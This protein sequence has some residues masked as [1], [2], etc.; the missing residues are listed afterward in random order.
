MVPKCRRV[1]LSK[2]LTSF[3]LRGDLRAPKKKDKCKRRVFCMSKQLCRGCYNECQKRHDVYHSRSVDTVNMETLRKWSVTDIK[4]L[5][6]LEECFQRIEHCEEFFGGNGDPGHK[7]WT[8]NIMLE[9]VDIRYYYKP[10]SIFMQYCES[11]SRVFGSMVR[12]TKLA[13]QKLHEQLYPELSDIR[14]TEAGKRAQKE[15]EQQAEKDLEEEE[16][17]KMKEQER[18][19]QEREEQEREEQKVMDV[20]E[21]GTELWVECD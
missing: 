9:N 16:E 7:N 14:L 1:F 12:E 13:L 8:K 6:F 21:V 20:R 2:N 15:R 10:D 5:V 4:D 18:E 17:R 3:L 11:R 19:E